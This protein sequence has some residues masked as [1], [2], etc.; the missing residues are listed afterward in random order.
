MG[1]GDRY[2]N[3]FMTLL[4]QTFCPSRLT[5]MDY[6]NSLPCPLASVW[7]QPVGCPVRRSKRR[8]V[9]SGYLYSWLLPCKVSSSCSCPLTKRTLVFTRQPILKLFLFLLTEF[10]WFL[11]TLAPLGIG[12]VT[13]PSLLTLGFH[14]ILPLSL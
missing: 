9:R 2:L 3:Y 5:C 6:I 4:K 11:F 13:V 8:R 14:S 12:V 7:V 10:C 1:R